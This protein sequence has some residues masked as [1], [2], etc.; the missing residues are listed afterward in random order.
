MHLGMDIPVADTVSH[1]PLKD[2]VCMFSK[3]M[4]EQ[5]HSVKKSVTTNLKKNMSSGRKG[6]RAHNA[7]PDCTVRIA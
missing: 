1:K 7:E 2:Y 5:V 4:D 3:G 6:L